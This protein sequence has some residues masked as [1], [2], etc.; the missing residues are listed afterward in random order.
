MNQSKRLEMVETVQRLYDCILD[1]SYELRR[2]DRA[3]QNIADAQQQI[4]AQISHLKHIFLAELTLREDEDHTETLQKLQM[5]R[6]DWQMFLARSTTRRPQGSSA[7]GGDSLTLSGGSGT[8]SDISPR[9]GSHSP[10]KRSMRSS[11]RGAVSHS[12]S[13]EREGTERAALV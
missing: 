10:K 1:V 4:R 3:L 8:S 6:A 13:A 9:G 11:A 7:G 2:T 5:T 12:R